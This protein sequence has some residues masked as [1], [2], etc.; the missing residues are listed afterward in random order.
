MCGTIGFFEFSPALET[1]LGLIAFKH[2]VPITDANGE[3]IQDES[4]YLHYLDSDIGEKI[5][6]EGCN[7]VRNHF[8]SRK[9][10]EQLIEIIQRYQIKQTLL[11]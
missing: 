8:S 5:A 3:L 1:E 11:Y 9:R 6:K 10:V 7:Y 2:Y 4:Y